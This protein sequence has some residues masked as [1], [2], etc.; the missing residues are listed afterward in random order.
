MMNFCTGKE[1][2]GFAGKLISEKHQAKLY[3]LDLTVAKVFALA[4]GGDIDFGGSE[5]KE[6]LTEE[7]KPV[8][9]DAEDKYGWWHLT[10]GEYLVEFNEKP[11]IPENH[12]GI[13]QPLERT[14]K[15]GGVHP[16][17]LL[18][19]GQRASSALLVVGKSGFNVKENAR[20]SSL[21]GIKP[22]D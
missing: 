20:I 2:L 14:L 11:E 4:K 10:E 21:W 6:A 3:S 7:V 8:K 17:L 16:T 1:I 19:P 5:E 9:K 12:I 22:G 15:A 13:L 18:S